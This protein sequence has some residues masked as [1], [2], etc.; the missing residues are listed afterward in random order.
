M[1]AEQKD[2]VSK[3]AGVALVRWALG[4]LFLVAGVSKLCMLSGFVTGYLVPAF[5]KTFL[6]A[7]MVSGFGYGLPF[8]ETLL[9][10]ALLLGLCRTMTLLLAG[11]TLMTLAVGQ[12]LIQG[13]GVVANI[14]LYILMTALVLLHQEHDTWGSTC[15]CRLCGGKRNGETHP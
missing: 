13:Q 7:W 4:V 12:M 6:P 3:S 10:V 1:N 5:A 14:M 9:G 15:R 2:G 11:L 8:V